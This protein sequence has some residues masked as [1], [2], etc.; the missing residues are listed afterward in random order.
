MRQEL[1]PRL[2]GERR[3]GGLEETALAGNGFDDP[4]VLQLGV[5]LGHRVPV[6]A[7]LLRQRAEGRKR[8]ARPQ[9]A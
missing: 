4:L 1:L 6:D 3:L 9:G 5:G 2:L 7:Q 8:L